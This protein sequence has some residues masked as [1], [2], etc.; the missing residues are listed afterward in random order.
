MSFADLFGSFVFGS[1]GMA[2]IVYGKRAG[3]VNPMLFG[4]GLMGF[5]YFVT[6]TWALYA[7]GSITT[8][9][10]LRFTDLEM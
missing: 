8:F 4:V 1:I 10:L 9:S 3:L 6:S 2:A 5:P 7:I